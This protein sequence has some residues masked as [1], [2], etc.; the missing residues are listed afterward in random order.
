[1]SKDLS[2]RQRECLELSATLHDDQIAARLGI[3]VHTVRKYIGE[4]RQRLGVQDRKAARRVLPQTEGGTNEGLPVPDPQPAEIGSSGIRSDDA[5]PET[6]RGCFARLPPPPSI[7][8][9]VV[10]MVLVSVVVAT[11]I[12]GVIGVM[13][14]TLHQ[15]ATLA[16]ANGS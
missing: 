3:S 4:A 13:R 12:N 11:A 15:T 14:G 1:M 7:L 5:E 16:P 10:I 2:R 9:R 6:V 8:M